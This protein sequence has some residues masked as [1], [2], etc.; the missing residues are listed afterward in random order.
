M[1]TKA[2]QDRNNQQPQLYCSQHFDVGAQSSL[3][4]A[5]IHGTVKLELRASEGHLRDERSESLNG[6]QPQRGSRE[7]D[8]WQ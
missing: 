3:P 6:H 2:G 4:S 7:S 8:G 1:G 5:L